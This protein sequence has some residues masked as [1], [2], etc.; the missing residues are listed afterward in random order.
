LS[1][2]Y[3]IYAYLPLLSALHSIQMLLLGT[4]PPYTKGKWWV[5]CRNG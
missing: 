4:L 5:S 2:G 1:D 3:H